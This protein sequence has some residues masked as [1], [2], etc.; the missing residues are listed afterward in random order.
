MRVDLLRSVKRKRLEWVDGEENGVVT[1]YPGVDFVFQIAL[2]RDKGEEGN[3]SRE[4]EENTI[5]NSPHS[6]QNGSFVTIF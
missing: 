1:A 5:T 4:N 3:R 6:I 2:S